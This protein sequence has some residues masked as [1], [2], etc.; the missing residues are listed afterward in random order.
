VARFLAIGAVIAFLLVIVWVA[1]HVIAGILS[2][3]VSIVAFVLAVAV[4]LY[5]LGKLA[6]RRSST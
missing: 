4:A 5:V 6:G 3:M 1:Y 2:V